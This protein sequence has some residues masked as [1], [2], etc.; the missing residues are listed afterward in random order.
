MLRGTGPVVLAPAAQVLGKLG[1][2]GSLYHL[3]PVMSA[4]ELAKG[5]TTA[6]YAQISLEDQEDPRISLGALRA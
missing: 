1:M 4:T 2:A 5:V 6:R 3:P